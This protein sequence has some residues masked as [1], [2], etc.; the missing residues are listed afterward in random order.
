MKIPWHRNQEKS[1]KID[2]RVKKFINDTYQIY[3]PSSLNTTQKVLMLIFLMSLIVWWIIG[4]N[5]PYNNMLYKGYQIVL[6]A[7]W[8]GSLVAIYLFKD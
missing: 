5:T 3:R 6:L 1:D 4:V 2:K 8:L 7:V